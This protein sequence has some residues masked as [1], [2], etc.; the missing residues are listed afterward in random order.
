[1]RQNEEGEILT[2]IIDYIIAKTEKKTP[3]ETIDLLEQVVDWCDESIMT[4][5]A[6][7]KNNPEQGGDWK[8][9]NGKKE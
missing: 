7:A 4:L 3:T 9:V 1:M 8:Q 2:D 5:G 6:V